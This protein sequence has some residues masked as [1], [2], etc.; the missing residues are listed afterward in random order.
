M[1]SSTLTNCYTFSQLMAGL[2]LNH[3]VR[4]RTESTAQDNMKIN[5]IVSHQKIKN[6]NLGHLLNRVLTR[7]VGCPSQPKYKEKRGFPTSNVY[8]TRSLDIS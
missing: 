6:I 8:P 1:N 7:R 5:M 4:T 2:W 3:R